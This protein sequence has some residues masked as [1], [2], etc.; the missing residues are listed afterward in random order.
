V[1]SRRNF[2]YASVEKLFIPLSKSGKKSLKVL[3]KIQQ[4]IELQDRIIEQAKNLKKILMQKLFTEGLYREG[5]KE[6][7][8]GLIPKSWKVV[9]SEEVAKITIWDCPHRK[10]TIPKV[11]VPFLKGKAEFGDIYPKPVS[12][13]LNH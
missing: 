5:E 1:E 3:D 6:A 8:I 11:K 9:R 7:E 10:L 4:A 13:A 12:I 2:N